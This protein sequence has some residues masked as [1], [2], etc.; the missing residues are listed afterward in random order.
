[1]LQKSSNPSFLNTISFRASDGLNGAS[2][3]RLTAYDVREPVSQTATPLGSACIS[4]G[5]LQDSER[6]RIPL[7]SCTGSTV[8]FLS[9]FVWSLER[10]S[11]STPSTESTPCRTVVQQTVVSWCIHTLI[12]VHGRVKI[13]CTY[14]IEKQAKEVLKQNKNG[15]TLY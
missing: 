13:I 8:G 12:C 5:T 11:Q 15:I 4:L 2:K 1:M 6:L 10:E 14:T 9:L 3:V 7:K